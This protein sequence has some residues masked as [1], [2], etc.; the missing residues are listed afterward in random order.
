MGM[1]VLCSGR[2]SAEKRVDLLVEAFDRAQV[3]EPRLHLVVAGTGPLVPL[4][5]RRLGKHATLHGWLERPALERAFAC[6]DIALSA[7]P[8]AVLD[9]QAA[10]VPVVTLRDSRAA[11]LVEDGRSGVVC[12]ADADALADA[13]VRLARSRA[14]RERLARGS[15]G[16]VAARAWRAAAIEEL[17]H[18]A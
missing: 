14:L 3:C 6:I 16:A 5:R 13:L 4:V 8:G 11:A 17:A 2:L 10:G 7:C 12:P 18:A 9:A 1:N 15:R